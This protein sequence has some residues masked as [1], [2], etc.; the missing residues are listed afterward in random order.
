MFSDRNKQQKEIV[1]GMYD[2]EQEINTERNPEENQVYNN[3]NKEQ[4]KSERNSVEMHHKINQVGDR[5]S[6]GKVEELNYPT[7]TKTY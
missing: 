1:K 4:S 2:M 3:R 5:I 6:E 7:I